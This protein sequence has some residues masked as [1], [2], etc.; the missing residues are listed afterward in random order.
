MAGSRSDSGCPCRAAAERGCAVGSGVEHQLRQHHDPDHQGQHHAVGMPEPAGVHSAREAG[1][2]GAD[3][4]GQHAEGQHHLQQQ[5][6]APAELRTDSG[7]T[8]AADVEEGKAAD[9]QQDDEDRHEAARARHHRLFD[10]RHHCVVE[11]AME[12]LQHSTSKH[13]APTNTIAQDRCSSRISGYHEAIAAAYAAGVRLPV[14]GI[15]PLTLPT[16]MLW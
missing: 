15:K 3:E 2:H 6:P 10:P 14:T 7:E 11:V 13:T 5:Q 9:E 1:A 12:R 16:R 4:D 8:V